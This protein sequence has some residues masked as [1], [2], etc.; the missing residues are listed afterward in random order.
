LSLSGYGGKNKG[1]DSK[2]CSFLHGDSP[3]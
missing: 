3:D 2:N 1:C